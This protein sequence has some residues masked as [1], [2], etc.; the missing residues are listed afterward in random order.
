MEHLI[1]GAFFDI[2]HVCSFQFSIFELDDSQFLALCFWFTIFVIVYNMGIPRLLK[3]VENAMTKVHISTLA[4][5][6]ATIDAFH[7]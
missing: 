7:W 4:N 1:F 6:T 2:I 3:Y 5:Q